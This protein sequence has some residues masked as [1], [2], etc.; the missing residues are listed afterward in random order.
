V[1]G[2]FSLAPTGEH[3][4]L[5]GTS[6]STL[7]FRINEVRNPILYLNAAK[8]IGTYPQRRLF[9]N[10]VHTNLSVG[11]EHKGIRKRTVIAKSRSK[12]VPDQNAWFSHT[13][14]MDLFR[15]NWLDMPPIFVVC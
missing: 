2:K 8:H 6:G 9:F 13:Y 14:G 7:T 5:W 15:F 3:Y 4:P 11:S 10:V 12:P 1:I